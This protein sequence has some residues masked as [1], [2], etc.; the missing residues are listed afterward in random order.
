M[1]NNPAL[2]KYPQGKFIFQQLVMNFPDAKAVHIVGIT[3]KRN[4]MH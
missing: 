3:C 4:H 1:Q 2:E